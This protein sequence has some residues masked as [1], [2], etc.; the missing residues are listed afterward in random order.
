VRQISKLEHQGIIGKLEALI[1]ADGRFR[2]RYHQDHRRYIEERWAELE[3]RDRLWI[4][5]HGL[6]ATFKERGIGGLSDWDKVKC[7]H[8]HY[9]HHLVREN[10]I[11]EWLD[12]NFEIVECARGSL[13]TGRRTYN[14]KRGC[15]GGEDEKF[16]CI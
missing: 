10:V 2:A 7:L 3:E 13:L 8:M 1:E 14:T 15:D 5:E 16:W 6:T 11:G 9:A 4:E 12:E